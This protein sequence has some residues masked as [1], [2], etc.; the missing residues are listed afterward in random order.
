MGIPRLSTRVPDTRWR[1]RAA[2]EEGRECLKR[3]NNRQHQ[4]WNQGWCWN[5]DGA[6]P[7]KPLSFALTQVPHPPGSSSGAPFNPPQLGR[8][9]LGN[10]KNGHPRERVR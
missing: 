7:Q 5:P 2:A 6:L 10:R 8:R 3:G 1:L 9:H 4:G